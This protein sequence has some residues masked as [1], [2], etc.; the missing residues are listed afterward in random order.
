[1]SEFPD[2]AQVEDAV[3]SRLTSQ[4]GLS[5]ESTLALL[6]ISENANFAVHDPH[7]GTDGV[8]RIHRHDYHQRRDI[9]SELAWM[10]A[11]RRETDLL[12]PDPIPTIRG[13]SVTVL[14]IDGARA[15]YATMFTRVPGRNLTLADA[16]PRVYKRLGVISAQLHH[17]AR[18]WQRPHGFHRY[19][20]DLDAMLTER[21]RFG[22]WGNHPRLT[23]G[24][25]KLLGQVAEIIAGRIDTFS[26]ERDAI[27]LAHTDLHALNLMVDGDDLWSIDFDDCGFSWYLQDIAPA[28]ACFEDGPIVDELA[29]AWIEGYEAFR[30]L[31]T[32]ERTVLPDFVMLRR[33]LLL[34]WSATHPLAELP[35]GFD[36]IVAVSTAAAQNYLRAAPRK[37]TR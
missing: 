34:G 14:P 31:T 8:I 11:I 18:N 3:R 1:M 32:A 33:M 27:G 10:K 2:L 23:A 20:W 22:Y 13:E 4:Y 6:T 5:G 17:Q 25:Q 19:R 24:D 37:V 12:I 21:A 36:D 30:P 7:S 28:L 9:E 15:R 29:E 16:T 35:G 26:A